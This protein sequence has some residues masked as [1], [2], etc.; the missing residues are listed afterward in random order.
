MRLPL[1]R[2]VVFFLLWEG[3][4]GLVDEM[5][6]VPSRVPYYRHFFPGACLSFFP[7]WGCF[8]R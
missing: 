2:R 4:Q 6:S 8:V 1:F 7:R 5:V 3:R